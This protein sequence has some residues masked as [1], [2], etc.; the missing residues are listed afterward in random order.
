MCRLDFSFCSIGC[1]IT[2]K[3]LFDLCFD[4]SLGGVCSA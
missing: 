2:L 4:N 3:A 1:I